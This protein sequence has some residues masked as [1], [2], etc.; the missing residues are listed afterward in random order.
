MRKA[1]AVRSRQPLRRF[2]LVLG[3]GAAVIILHGVFGNTPHEVLRNT[4]SSPV[5]RKA[6]PAATPTSLSLRQRVV[7]IA[8]SQVGYSTDPANS[9]CNKF[10]SYWDSGTA[11]CP[12]GE[13][14]EEWCADFAAWVWRKAGV[15]LSYGYEPGQLNARAASFYAWGVDHDRRP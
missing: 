7:A 14:D 9:Y 1:S 13:S 11:D 5:L 15:P 3:A 6:T 10:S 8:K 12:S 4:D 2:G